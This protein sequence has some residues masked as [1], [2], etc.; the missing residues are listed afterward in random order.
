MK[1]PSIDK[2]K[3]RAVSEKLSLPLKQGLRRTSGNVPGSNAGSSIDFQDHRPYVPGDDPRH[4]DWQAYARS[5]QYTMKL[6][7]EEVRPLVDVAVDASASMFVDAEKATRA[8]ELV[9][10]SSESALRAGAA[11]RVF[12]VGGG[13]VSVFEGSAD[14]ITLPVSDDPPAVQR[15]PWRPGSLRVVVSDLLFPASPASLLMPLLAGGGR[16]I[17][18]IP[19][20]SSEEDPDWLGN[21]ELLDV[22]TGTRADHF[23]RP[24][25]LRRYHD[26]YR[27][28]FTIWQTTARGH[29]IPFA[30]IPAQG[31]LE[32]ALSFS[33]IR[34]GAVVLG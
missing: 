1:L 17:L 21:T 22:E 19:F 24:D 18:L 8:L 26:A 23:F 15:V 13:D 11:L 10:F 14:S 6:Y 27:T 25:D 30:R 31:S 9:H 5:G 4:I 20:S 16:V 32:E 7:R 34:E 29:G 12:W 3:V 2:T 33:A 28:H